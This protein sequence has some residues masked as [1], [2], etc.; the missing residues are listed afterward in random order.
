MG[1][2]RQLNYYQMVTGDWRNLFRQL[3][4]IDAVT[5]DDVRRVASGMLVGKNRTVA[6]IRTR[7][8]DAQ[9]AAGR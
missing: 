5:V 6:M 1:L 7:N 3:D 4:R 9:P 2:A 8:E